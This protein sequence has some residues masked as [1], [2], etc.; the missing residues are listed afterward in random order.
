MYTLCNDS[1]QAFPR[2]M[3]TNDW[4][5]PLPHFL[6][7]IKLCSTYYALMLVGL[8]VYIAVVVNARNQIDLHALISNKV[9]AY[10]DNW[11]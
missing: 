2:Q 4:T 9:L 1:L 5:T 7:P 3:K 6:A 8:S 11:L 10:T